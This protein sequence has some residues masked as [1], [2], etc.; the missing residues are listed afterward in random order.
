MAV[1]KNTMYM[2]GGIVEVYMH[3]V[4]GGYVQL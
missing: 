2:F 1:V 4:D 3:A